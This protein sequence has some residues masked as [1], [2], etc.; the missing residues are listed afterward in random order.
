MS[1]PT[2]NNYGEEEEEVE[3]MEENE[4][5]QD[6]D[7]FWLKGRRSSG[8]GEMGSKCLDKNHVVV[9]AYYYDRY[10]R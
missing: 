5:K 6:E 10:T 9:V 7:D 1:N 2:P 8:G 3:E 4:D